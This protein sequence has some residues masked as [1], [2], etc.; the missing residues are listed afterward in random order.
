M[1][2]WSQKTPGQNSCVW[3]ENRLWNLPRSKGR[4][5]V[6]L[7][8]AIDFF[9]FCDWSDIPQKCILS[10]SSSEYL[11][12]TRQVSQRF[13]YLQTRI[14]T[15]SPPFEQSDLNW[16]FCDAFQQG[17]KGFQVPPER[18]NTV[19]P[20]QFNDK[21]YTLSHGSVV[22]AAITSCTNTSNPSV[23]LGAGGYTTP[24]RHHWT[25]TLW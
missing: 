25:F 6:L 5:S 16:A 3:H 22:I 18:H 17:F 4:Y 1:L 11:S 14:T 12:H 21:Q 23:M 7:S 15:L 19:V 20:F 9:F 24:L 13:F 2:Q 8:E 10:K